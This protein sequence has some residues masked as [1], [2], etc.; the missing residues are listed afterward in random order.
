MWRR[1][2]ACTNH[3]PVYF[4]N[5]EVDFYF[6]FPLKRKR[7][8][9]L[10]PQVYGFWEQW[11]ARA[12]SSNFPSLLVST[13]PFSLDTRSKAVKIQRKKKKARP[14]MLQ[15]NAR[16]RAEFNAKKQQSSPFWISSD[17]NTMLFSPEKE[18]SPQNP[19][20]LQMSP[21]HLQW[22]EIKLPAEE[23][24][25]PADKPPSPLLTWDTIFHIRLSFMSEFYSFLLWIELLYEDISCVIFIYLCHQP[26]VCSAG[27]ACSG[28]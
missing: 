7:L 8:I 24:P 9:L 10:G 21:N 28:S 14:L 19:G 11:P 20:E 16:W 26:P 18:Q 25:S 15:R 5:S 12:R 6:E 22:E 13:F 1:Q 2:H 4:Q 17:E 3:V 23:G 27:Q